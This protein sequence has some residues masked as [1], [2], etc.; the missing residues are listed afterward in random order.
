MAVQKFDEVFKS[1]QNLKF[2]ELKTM[3]SFMPR[4]KEMI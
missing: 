3:I 4:D 2:T 1:N